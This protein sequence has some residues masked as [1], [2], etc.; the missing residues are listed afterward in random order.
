MKP[1]GS[2][3]RADARVPAQVRL[4]ELE[5]EFRAQIETVLPAG[6]HR[7]IWIGMRCALPGG[8]TSST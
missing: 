6:L 2:T 3:D 1:A 4:D 8:R 7:L 5:V